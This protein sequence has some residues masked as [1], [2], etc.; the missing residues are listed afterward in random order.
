MP[1]AQSW[2]GAVLERRIRE[3]SPVSAIGFW[4]A[5]VKDFLPRREIVEL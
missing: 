5:G 3:P 1:I 4:N 2:Q